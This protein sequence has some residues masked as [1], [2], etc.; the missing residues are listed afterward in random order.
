VANI[1]QQR[2]QIRR[3]WAAMSMQMPDKLVQIIAKADKL[4]V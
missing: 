1:A 2:L 4:S 3:Q